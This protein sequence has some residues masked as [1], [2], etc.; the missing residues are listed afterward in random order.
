M[1]THVKAEFGFTDN[2][3]DDGLAGFTLGQVFFESFC[4]KP[5]GG[6]TAYTVLVLA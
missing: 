1:L 3:A 6:R 4:P 2:V 5:S